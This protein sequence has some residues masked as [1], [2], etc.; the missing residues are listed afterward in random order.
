MNKST[1]ITIVQILLLAL[2]LSLLFTSLILM[3]GFFFTESFWCGSAGLW[4]LALVYL[5]NRF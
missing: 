4:C 1:D 5:S 2:G 3:G